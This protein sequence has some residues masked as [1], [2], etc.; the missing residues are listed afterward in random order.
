MNWKD[1]FNIFF[2]FLKKHKIKII[3]GLIFVAVCNFL[4]LSPPKEFKPGSVAIVEKGSSL[5]VVAKKLKEDGII[6][7]TTFFKIFVVLYGGDKHLIPTEYFFE[8]SLPVYVVA[9]RITKGEDGFGPIK[10]TIPEGFNN[11]EV[12]EAMALQL[13]HFDSLKFLASA[14][15]KEGYLFPDT[16]F[17]ERADTEEIVIQSMNEN[18]KNKIAEVQQDISAS[19]KTEKEVLVMASIIER[20]ANGD[21]DRKF[22]SGILWRRLSIGMPLQAD[23][24]PITYEQRGLPANPIGNPGL[25]AI[26]SAIYPQSSNYLY[27]LHDK[28]GNIHY[29]RSF[30]EHRANISKYLR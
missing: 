30:E 17:F 18:F 11:V 1:Y 13:P 20:E 14:K 7:S 6:R 22:I 16:Y 15:S 19:G 26:E 21:E 12:A 5:G 4:F 3:S 2:D 10:V 25:L 23:A 29:A 8:K 27:Y 24:A 28:A 9:K